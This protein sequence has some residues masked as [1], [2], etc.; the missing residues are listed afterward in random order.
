MEL[1]QKRVV[2]KVIHCLKI[3]LII[4]N[5][6]GPALVQQYLQL[7]CDF[8]IELALRDFEISFLKHLLMRQPLAHAVEHVELIH[9]HPYVRKRFFPILV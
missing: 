8:S 2:D 9:A 5:G 7:L 4:I 1:E 3:I 6:T